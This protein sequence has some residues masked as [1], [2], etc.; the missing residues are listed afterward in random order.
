M[1]RKLQANVI[2]ATN[3]NMSHTAETEQK[4]GRLTKLAI[5]TAIC[6]GYLMVI[7]DA[8]V[9][10]VALPDMRQQL[11]ATGTALQWVVNSYTLML[12]SF[13]LTAGALGDR[14]GNK[15]IFL[16]GLSL[17][18]IASALC[19]LAPTLWVLEATRVLQGVG[20]AF[21]IPTSL[22]LLSNIFSEPVERARAIGIWGAIASIGAAGG[23]VLGGI[24]VNI[25]GWRSVFL[26]NIPIGALGI[27]LTLRFI[28]TVPRLMQRGLDLAG[29]I[30][31]I[32]ALFM[33][34][35]AFTEGNSWGWRSLPI[36]GALA[37]FALAL[38]AFLLIEH[39]THNPMLPLKLFSSPTFSA[40]NTV[41][42]LL[43]FGFYGQL[44][45]IN[46]F[47]QQIKGYSPLIT[48][49][50][51]LPEAGIMII[52]STLSGRLT[53]RVGPRWSMVLGLAIGC[54]G[55][56]ALTL[57]DTRMSYAVLSIMLVA[58]GFGT[59]F[60]MPA[61]TT[62]TI[63]AAP[64]ER[65]GIASATLNSSR[66][67]GVALGVALLGSLVSRQAFFVPGMHIAFLMA[68]GAF[69]IGCL[70]SLVAVRSGS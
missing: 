33:L 52:A 17:F 35:L 44:F 39:F 27:L 45:C 57:V 41:G 50:A 49:L 2:E 63:A 61:M 20:A 14:Q 54:C 42:L 67:V 59:A 55:L 46:L 24:L 66:Q 40:A 19:G 68:G 28:P 47:F 3:I 10:N 37:V 31:G 53:G 21:L 16:V 15:R 38:V 13:L 9:V 36:V 70:L 5:M 7:I 62:A 56:L 11:A 12:A 6:T 22:S 69:L 25:F 64:A 34:T 60:T 23:P 18:T 43:N 32:I 8:T 58:V 26:I 51:L 65:S 1:S 48:G 4:N 30:A 29:Q